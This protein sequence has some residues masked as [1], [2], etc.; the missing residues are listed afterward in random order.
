VLPTDLPLKGTLVIDSPLA[1]T[2]QC[3]EALFPGP[4]PIPSCAFN[5]SESTLK[6]K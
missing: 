5:T 3:G 6:C 2:G 4:R 1:R